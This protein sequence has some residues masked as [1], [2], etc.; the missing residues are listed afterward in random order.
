MIGTHPRRTSAEPAVPRG[1]EPGLRTPRR[2]GGDARQQNPGAPRR[3]H[4]AVQTHLPCLPASIQQG[5]SPG[6]TG[7]GPLESEPNPLYGGG[8]ESSRGYLGVA[9]T[10]MITQ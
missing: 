10:K 9:T 6:E 1:S 5:D 4:F 7:S 2:G 8:W 3:P